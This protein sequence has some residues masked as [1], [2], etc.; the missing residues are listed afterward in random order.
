MYLRES[1]SF[2]STEEVETTLLSHG[3]YQPFDNNIVKI[4]FIAKG[5]VIIDDVRFKLDLNY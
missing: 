4:A 3:L 2:S 5:I 1:F